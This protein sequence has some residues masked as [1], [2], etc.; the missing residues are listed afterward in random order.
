MSFDELTQAEAA[1][2][3]IMEAS[4][5]A[6]DKFIRENQMIIDAWRDKTKSISDVIAELNDGSVNR[7][8]SGVDREVRSKPL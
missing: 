8:D 1:F 5:A 6:Q 2:Q 4:L 7:P 3:R